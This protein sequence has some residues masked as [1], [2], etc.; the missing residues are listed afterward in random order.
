MDRPKSGNFS[1]DEKGQRSCR[2]PLPVKGKGRGFCNCKFGRHSVLVS[3]VIRL[4]KNNYSS[5][6]RNID[7]LLPNSDFSN[8]DEYE[9]KLKDLYGIQVNGE[10]S[11]LNETLQMGNA[12]LRV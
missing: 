7:V 9:K 6:S 4:W 8:N 12:I 3:R 11:S 2:F 1:C 5:I 10:K